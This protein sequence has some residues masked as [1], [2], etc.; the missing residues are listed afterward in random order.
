[1]KRLYDESAL[2][3]DNETELME[4]WRSQKV[5]TF[6]CEVWK[7]ESCR[8]FACT[9]IIDTEILHI[10]GDENWLLS[11]KSIND[12]KW[13]FLRL[14]RHKIYASFSMLSSI[15]QNK[16]F[17]A[18]VFKVFLHN[19]M[20]FILCYAVMNLFFYSNSLFRNKSII[21]KRKFMLQ[22][23]TQL[24]YQ[25]KKIRKHFLKVHKKFKHTATIHEFHNMFYMHN[26]LA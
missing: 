8:Q 16:I 13:C 18:H 17:A 19:R 21:W 24:I 12:V 11:N 23:I 3:S 14:A 7:K 22:N 5:W 6:S 25:L 20:G 1:M 2:S 9:R 4:L 10:Y 15:N 26:F